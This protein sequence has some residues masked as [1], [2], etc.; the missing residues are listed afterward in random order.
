MLRTKLKNIK[1]VKFLYDSFRMSSIWLA[2]KQQRLNYQELINIIPDISEQYNTSVLDTEYLNLKVRSV[3]A[4]Q[5]DLIKRI[6]KDNYYLSDIGDSS[7]NHIIYTKRFFNNIISTSVNCDSNAIKKI[8]SK[9]LYAEKVSAEDYVREVGEVDLTFLFQTLEH[10]ENPIS[11]LKKAKN[12]TKY[13]IITVPYLKNSRIG[14]HHLRD[15]NHPFW[16]GDPED[17][18]Y[19]ELSPEDWKLMFEFTGWKVKYEK[20][21]YQ[22]PRWIPFVSW[23]L[24]KYWRRF[25]FEGF[26]GVILFKE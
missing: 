16:K 11:F 12:H 21:Y 17:I 4:F 20:I 25:D 5:M 26:Y 3:H 7:G 19:Y 18:H 22:Y 2:G 24:K 1:W 23:L 13:M 10:F 15:K 8:K 9:G 14:F 6:C